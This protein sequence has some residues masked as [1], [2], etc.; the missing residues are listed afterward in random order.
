MSDR[1]RVVVLFRAGLGLVFLAAF[2]SLAV[3]LRDLVGTRGLLPWAEFLARLGSTHAGLLDR[4]LAFPT[5]F[6]FIH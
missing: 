1:G 6:L 2:L 5:L 4:L 3:Q